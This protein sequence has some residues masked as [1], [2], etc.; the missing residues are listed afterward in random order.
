M[1]P[2]ACSPRTPHISHACS[3]FSSGNREVQTVDSADIASTPEKQPDP[4]H[5]ASVCQHRKGDGNEHGMLVRAA[6]G[7]GDPTTDRA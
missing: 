4:Q 1:F 7:M 3:N 5:D 6:S 2:M